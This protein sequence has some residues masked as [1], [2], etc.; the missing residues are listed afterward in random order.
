MSDPG[1]TGRA[2]VNAM[3][4]RDSD[5][6]T[7]RVPAAS[8]AA[9]AGRRTGRRRAG[10][11]LI[12][13]LVV[14]AV[15]AILISILLPA[16]GTARGQ[17][18]RIVGA[19]TQSQLF[20][21]IA[22]YAAESED[23]YPGV[24]TSGWF[25]QRFLVGGAQRPSVQQ[26]QEYTHR[27]GSSPVQSFDWICPGMDGDALPS[28]RE[29]RFYN[30]LE[31]FADPAMRERV[32][33]YFGAGVD[34]GASE[35]ATFINT[36]RPGRPARGVS[37][38]MPF[39]FQAFGGS[40]RGPGAGI[41]ARILWMDQGLTA[42]QAVIPSGY[43]PKSSA[44]NRPG[45]K[46]AIADGFRYWDATGIDFDASYASNFYGSFTSSSPV[47]RRDTAYGSLS[48]SGGR[49]LAL[50]YRHSGALNAMFWDG[51]GA[52]ITREESFNPALWYPAGSRFVAGADT[53]TESLRF[54]ERDQI[55]N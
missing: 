15:L 49:Q 14:V 23:W 3:I 36:Y 31:R 42:N 13:L 50:S 52:L 38:L 17:A 47:F 32:P 7:T 24:N 55:L 41:S 9:G 18:W 10:F 8:R 19:S 44:I 12:E 2:G 25:V 5:T 35:M 53:A 16:L 11:T 51:H 28:D 48:P 34:Q 54:Y 40:G 30:I 39:M 46:I 6:K 1:E 45:S 20:K 26:V 27:S 37:Y 33:V 22:S 29:A 21:G 4:H 43:R